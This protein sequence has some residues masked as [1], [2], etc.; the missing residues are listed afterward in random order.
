MGNLKRETIQKLGVLSRWI[1]LVSLSFFSLESFAQPDSWLMQEDVVLTYRELLQLAAVAPPAESESIFFKAPIVT[2]NDIDTA[3]EEMR[4]IIYGP[5]NARA[6]ERIL[7]LQKIENK[8]PLSN[9]EKNHILHELFLLQNAAHSQIELREQNEILRRGQAQSAIS[10][11]I[12][13]GLTLAGGYTTLRVSND[14]GLNQIGTWGIYGTLAALSGLGAF[15]SYY[16]SYT[17]SPEHY[18]GYRTWDSQ[19][20]H[21]GPKIDADLFQSFDKRRG[22][23]TN[24]FPALPH[25]SSLLNRAASL[26]FDNPS[27]RAAPN[28]QEPNQRTDQ[29]GGQTA[30]AESVAI[31]IR[32]SVIPRF[33]VQNRGLIDFYFTGMDSGTFSQ[34]I[35]E[36]S[37]EI[38]RRPYA[39]WNQMVLRR[40]FF[41]ALNRKDTDAL[42]ILMHTNLKDLGHIFVPEFE[43]VFLLGVTQNNFDLT[44]YFLRRNDHHRLPNLSP[45][46]LAQAKE[47][48]EREN[49]AEMARLISDFIAGPQVHPAEP[50][51]IRQTASH[52]RD[53]ERTAQSAL[54]LLKKRY[55]QKYAQTFPENR[56]AAAAILPMIQAKID[57]LRA[58][59]KLTSVQTTAA[60]GLLTRIEE[61][62]DPGKPDYDPTHMFLWNTVEK[63]KNTKDL[64]RIAYLA[65]EDESAYKENTGKIMTP[66]DRDDNWEA[67]I[68][69][70]LYDGEHAYNL[71]QG[72]H[73]DRSRYRPLSSCVA[74]VDHRIIHALTGIHPDVKIT[75]GSSEKENLLTWNRAQT[76]FKEQK[77]AHFFNSVFEDLMDE[78]AKKKAPVQPQRYAGHSR[79][80]VVP[81]TQPNEP[82]SKADYI[83]Q[84]QQFVTERAKAELGTEILNTDEFKTIL[85]TI[86][87]NPDR[88]LN[89]L[90]AVGIV[91]T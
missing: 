2:E 70:A 37:E 27:I 25:Y 12:S 64:L 88:M 82:T 61:P 31:T 90:K 81:I 21:W 43:R 38:K 80:R 72:R 1:T 71:D 75:A 60:K 19:L 14:P 78:W 7:L 79:A 57:H 8:A 48:A 56:S 51:H 74:G 28:Q 66:Q 6:V 24:V 4:T 77:K 49:R 22:T 5:K 69:N 45:R 84:Y 13:T 83:K 41:L 59:K 62:Y 67:W 35:R 29:L 15:Q 26:I 30:G 91:P 50:D 52:D 39:L 63:K 34:R 11:A 85:E 40:L 10:I 33:S 46:I 32:S 23:N 42:A 53:T 18:L 47:L 54:S 89:S 3:T 65:L 55:R 9:S 58:K 87:D 44:R 36:I 73:P 86:D 16:S 20:S 76:R 68:L 17:W